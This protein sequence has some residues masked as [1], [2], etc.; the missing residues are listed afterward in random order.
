MP[1]TRHLLYENEQSQYE[2]IPQ[3]GFFLVFNQQTIRAALSL[4]R[5][6]RLSLDRRCSDVPVVGV[7][8]NFSS[9]FWSPVTQAQV[10]LWTINR[11]YPEYGACR[12]YRLIDMLSA[13]AYL[14]YRRHKAQIHLPACYRL[15]LIREILS[16]RSWSSDL[17]GQ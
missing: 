4:S 12:C 13:S 15:I 9:L 14:C 16:L 7:R 3:L 6:W 17:H 8:S 11:P 5:A 1:E 2:V 10:S